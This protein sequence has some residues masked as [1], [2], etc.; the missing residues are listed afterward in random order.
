MNIN[1]TI[2]GQT[3][4]FILIIMFCMYYIW[5]PIILSIENRKKII[6]D[7]LLFINKKK[8][9]IIIAENKIYLK[10]KKAHKEY[11]II[12]KQAQKLS[13]HI[14]NEAQVESKKIYKETINKAQKKIEYEYIIANESLKKETVKIAMS[15][16]EKIIK[17]SFKKNKN[18]ED[19]LLNNFINKL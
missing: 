14:I 9:D 18:Y 6:Q 2:I 15:I 7:Q 5:P 11:Q 10:I 1:A 17:D 12:I 8:K 16:A 13:D 4:T 3:I 19:D